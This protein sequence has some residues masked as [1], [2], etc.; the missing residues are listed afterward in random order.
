M[1]P[2]LFCHIVCLTIWGCFTIWLNHAAKV[3]LEDLSADGSEANLIIYMLNG[4]TSFSE[5]EAE[6]ALFDSANSLR[7]AHLVVPSIGDDIFGCQPIKQKPLF[8]HS[9]L[10]LQNG[11][12]SSSLKASYAGQMG[13]AGFIEGDFMA[14]LHSHLL[15]PDYSMLQR[16]LMVAM[17]SLPNSSYRKVLK[18]YAQQNLGEHALQ[19]VIWLPLDCCVVFLVSAGMALYLLSI[20]LLLGIS[21]VSGAVIRVLLRFMMLKSTKVL[22]A[23]RLIEKSELEVGRSIWDCCV[24]CL[25][26]FKSGDIVRWLPCD[27]IFHRECIDRW[28]KMKSPICPICKRTMMMT[29]RQKLKNS[30][31]R[32]IGQLLDGK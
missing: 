2:T 32:T 23:G 4:K 26:D 16:I 27:H 1:K 28:F 30:L 5:E 14:A 19:S 11:R 12:C 6:V 24:F 10:I 18:A 7:Q 21:I 9:W 31:M 20:K 13:Y 3:R 15:S 29:M 17:Y 8:L 22:S 25:N